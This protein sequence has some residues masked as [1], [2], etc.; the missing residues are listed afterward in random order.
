MTDKEVIKQLV[1]ALVAARPIDGVQANV[2]FAAIQAGREALKSKDEKFCDANCVWTNHHPDCVH[3]RK[4]PRDKY[5]NELDQIDDG[6]WE[7]NPN[8]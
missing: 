5:S 3:N 2:Q 1:D 7:P 6:T 8:D 4:Q